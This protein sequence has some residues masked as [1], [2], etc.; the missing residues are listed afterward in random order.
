MSQLEAPLLPGGRRHDFFDRVGH[1]Q[2]REV[3]RGGLAGGDGYVLPLRRV[4]HRDHSKIVHPGGQSRDAVAAVKPDGDD[5]PGLGYLYPGPRNGLGAGTIVTRPAIV[6]V[7]PK[8]GPP[9]RQPAQTR[10]RT[11]PAI[12][13]RISWTQSSC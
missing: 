10:R 8:A 13:W 1:R 11:G 7:W 3:E 2:E 5:L 4:A 12:E 6:P 9:V